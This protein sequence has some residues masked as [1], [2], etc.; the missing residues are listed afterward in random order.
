[1]VVARHKCVFPH[2]SNPA[3]SMLSFAA[4]LLSGSDGEWGG[5][6]GGAKKVLPVS[7]LLTSGCSP[8]SSR[9]AVDKGEIQEQGS[10]GH[11]FQL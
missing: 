3:S 8:A 2:K 11:G 9:V 4:L 1:M 7:I 10:L 5:G 6:V